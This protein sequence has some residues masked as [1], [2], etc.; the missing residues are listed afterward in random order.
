MDSRP[1]HAQVEGKLWGEYIFLI[2]QSCKR[3]VRN[4]L[5]REL[6]LTL[7]VCYRLCA[8]LPGAT[9]KIEDA[10]AE[11]RVGVKFITP[12]EAATSRACCD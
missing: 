4:F 10:V 3:N 6:L 5:N 8:A 2:G 1:Y 11:I 7:G 12:S 9:K